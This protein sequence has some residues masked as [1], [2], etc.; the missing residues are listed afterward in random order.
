[1]PMQADAPAH[2]ARL[3]GLTA[4]TTYYYRV[5]TW[6]GSDAVALTPNDAGASGIATLQTGAFPVAVPTF[7]VEGAGFNRV[8]VAPLVNA[9]TV[10]VL[11]AVGTVVWAYPDQSGL[12]ITRARLSLDKGSV[13]YNAVGPQG[14]AT[15][16]SAVV[17]VP[18]DA[19]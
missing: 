19:S 8:V 15:P 5:V 18:L 16:N 9:N 17:R 14:V 1:T 2:T 6:V 3:L 12:S 4:N 13:L 10:V 7:Q 11:D